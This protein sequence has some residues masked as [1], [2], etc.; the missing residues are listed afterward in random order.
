MVLRLRV[1]GRITTNSFAGMQST[2][3]ECRKLYIGELPQHSRRRLTVRCAVSRYWITTD[4]ISRVLT[5]P[6]GL[7]R[8]LAPGVSIERTITEKT[9]Q[10][11]WVDGRR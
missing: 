2:N 8:P 11:C 10:R 6:G 7:W 9:A 3:C 1:G 5:T 4:S